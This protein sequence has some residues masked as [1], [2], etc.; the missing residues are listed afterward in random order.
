MTPT[1]SPRIRFLS[2]R[3]DEGAVLTAL[4]KIAWTDEPPGEMDYAVLAALK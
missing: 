4:A 1:P 2:C 3:F